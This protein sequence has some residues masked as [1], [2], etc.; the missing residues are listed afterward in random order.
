MAVEEMLRIILF[1]LGPGRKATCSAGG[2][3]A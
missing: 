1:G 2:V 3:D